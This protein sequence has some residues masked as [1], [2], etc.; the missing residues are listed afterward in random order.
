[1]P[2]AAHF[3]AASK[4]RFHLATYVGDY[5]VSTVGEYWPERSVREIH[6]RIHD[7]RWLAD[8]E[9]LLGDAFDHAYMNR[10]GYEDIGADR[11]YETMVFKAKKSEE[12]D[13]DYQC[14]PY[15]IIV[16]EEV[17]FDGY[18]TATDAYKGH[19]ALCNKWSNKKV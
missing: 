7:L 8:H 13:P 9:H 19:L 17:D 2:H 10:F 16:Q 12:N 3:I 18:K 14:C 4:C 1:M 15:S 11:T 5:I 6:A